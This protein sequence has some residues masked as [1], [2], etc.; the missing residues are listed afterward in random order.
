MEHQIRYRPVRTGRCTRGADSLARARRAAALKAATSRCEKAQVIHTRTL[1]SAP[2]GL[3][4]RRRRRTSPPS[5]GVGRSHLR[6]GCPGSGWGAGDGLGRLTPDRTPTPPPGEAHKGQ[7]RDL[8]LLA[9]LC[10]RGRARPIAH[11]S[12][13]DISLRPALGLR[14]VRQPPLGPSF[15]RAVRLVGPFG[16]ADL[17]RWCVRGGKMQRWSKLND[18]QLVL[19][20]MIGVERSQ[21]ARRTSALARRL[22]T[23]W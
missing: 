17:S 22:C 16:V 3:E 2:T 18:R 21:S 15:F 14:L 12:S 11:K 20:R 10:P 4:V 8:T 1:D 5:T 13:S 6:G 9:G 7:V 19:L 23:P